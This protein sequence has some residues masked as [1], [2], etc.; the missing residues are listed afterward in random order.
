MPVRRTTRRRTTRRAAPRRPAQG[1]KVIRVAQLGSGVQ[2]VALGIDGTVRDALRAA[3]IDVTN[4]EE[5]RVDNIVETLDVIPTNDS[6]ITI[7]PQVK[8]GA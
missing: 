5:V 2:E 8:G 3:G 1:H 7:V 4:G 6:L